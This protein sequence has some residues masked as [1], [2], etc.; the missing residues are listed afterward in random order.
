MDYLLDIDGNILTPWINPDKSK[1]SHGDS[2]LTF[3]MNHRAII[4]NGRI[5]PENNNFTFLLPMGSSVPDYMVCPIENLSNC[6][7]MSVLLMSD[8]IEKFNHAP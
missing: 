3:L 8:I 4:L 1:N 5:T 6:M 7:S 2:F